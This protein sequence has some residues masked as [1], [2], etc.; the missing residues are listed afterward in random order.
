[1][2]MLFTSLFF[3]YRV[4]SAQRKDCVVITHMVILI[5]VIVIFALFVRRTVY[6]DIVRMTNEM[7]ASQQQGIGFFWR[8]PTYRVSPLSGVLLYVVGQTHWYALMQ[9]IAAAV[10]YGSIC[11]IVWTLYKYLT[12]NRLTVFFVAVLLVSFSNFPAIIFG[13]RSW[14]ALSLGAAAVLYYELAGKHF[15]PC[16]VIAVVAA[17]IHFQAWSIVVIYALAVYCGSVIRRIACMICALY[18][19]VTVPL[20]AVLHALFPSSVLFADLY[21]KAGYYFIGGRNFQL[22]VSVPQLIFYYSSVIVA[23]AALMY[24]RKFVMLDELRQYS[25]SGSYWYF[26]VGYLCACIGSLPSGTPITRFAPTLFLIA[27]PAFALMLDHARTANSQGKVC[28]PFQVRVDA[29]IFPLSVLLVLLYCFS[30]SWT[31]QSLLV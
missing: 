22:Y 5:V 12:V 14:M 21:D 30:L 20:T 11:V 31:T 16:V 17:L 9:G 1:M 6:D 13:I 3:A 4:V 15:I 29:M 25:L 10:Y 18:G 28:A 7:I 8:I 19:W 24:C 23:A 2:A 27:T 26:A